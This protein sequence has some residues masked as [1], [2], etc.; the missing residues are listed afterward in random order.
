MRERPIIFS[1]PMVHAI[2]AG[3]KTQTRRIVKGAPTDAIE[4]VPSLLAN[5]GTLYDFRRHL[6]N[7]TAIRCPYGA[8]GDRLWVRETWAVR[9]IGPPSSYIDP[10]EVRAYGGKPPTP[11]CHLRAHGTDVIIDYS[12]H[13]TSIAELDRSPGYTTYR[14]AAPDRWRSPLFM[15]RWASRITLEITEVRVRRLQDISEEDAKAEGVAPF[16]LD[17][18]GDCW[19][20][21]KHRTAF[22][23]LWNEINGWN[24]DSWSS[25]PWVWAITF[26][27]VEQP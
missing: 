9:L 6:D 10:K 7:P 2:L 5:T 22:N 27:R 4:V 11:G 21:G 13:P 23:Y 1:A 17:P 14:T 18:E 12:A 24:P 26:K 16:P 8:P 20:D 15:P 3:T 19:S 25:N